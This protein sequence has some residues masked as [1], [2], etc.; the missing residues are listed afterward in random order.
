MNWSI[1][2]ILEATGG[3]L[4][5]G[6]SDLNFSEV[7]ID[8]R[9][10]SPDALFVAIRGETHD[11][12]RFLQEV[13]RQG[14]RGLVVQEKAE[15]PLNH[16]QW[17]AMGVACIAVDHTIGALGALASY[18]RQRRTM[19]V[20]AITGQSDPLFISVDA[21]AL[22]KAPAPGLDSEVET[23]RPGTGKVLAFRA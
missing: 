11:G 19:P 22:R 17:E 9:A 6:P 15:G 5:Y 10:I 18:Q 7:G 3:R 1:D 12:H 8:S 21:P 23:T 4:L 16:D 2:V 13:T 14:V 20:V